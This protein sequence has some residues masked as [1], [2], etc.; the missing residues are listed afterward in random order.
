VSDEQGRW[1][2]EA[3]ES[4]LSLPGASPNATRAALA[5]VAETNRIDVGTLELTAVTMELE[6]LF[7]RIVGR[8]PAIMAALA[9]LDRLRD[10]AAPVLLTGET[11]SGK[12]VFAQSLHA[13]SSRANGPF[14]AVNCSAIPAT[15]IEAELF[16]YRRGAF[17]GAVRDHV[18]FAQQAHGGTLFLDEIG[19]LP[20]ESQPK[21]LR[22]LEAHAVRPIGAT[23]DIPIDVRIVAATHRSLVDD[24][25]R[26]RFR[27]DLYYRLNVLEVRL[28]PLRERMAD[29]PA[30]AR[31]LLQR[32][33]QEV[34]IT[35]RAMHR[36]LSYDWPGNVRELR[37]ELERARVLSS[38]GP[39]EERH[40]SSHVRRPRRAVSPELGALGPLADR[41]V[42]YERDLVAEALKRTG[43]NQTKAA[44]LL[45]IRRN[46][47]VQKLARLRLRRKDPKTR[48]PRTGRG[49]RR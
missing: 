40:L 34:T 1:L 23:A 44:E 33:G 6:R 37:N 45:G 17:T 20:L 12:E 39:I 28:P 13:S 10:A 35:P 43:G 27:E 36:L 21:L 9:M 3:L 30:L 11:G 49:N 7:P 5:T 41:L 15:L 38:G 29:L 4:V 18:G 46:V 19:E 32:E 22:M 47:L 8:S 24:V 16:G 48:E 25:A 2:I 14:V 31:H 42:E 26:G